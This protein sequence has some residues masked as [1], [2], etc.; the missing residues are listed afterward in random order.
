MERDP[1]KRMRDILNQARKTTGRSP[2]E[3]PVKVSE[4]PKKRKRK[5]SGAAKQVVEEKRARVKAQNAPAPA[6]DVRTKRGK[7]V[8]QLQGAA[9]EARLRGVASGV[10]KH[11][12]SKKVPYTPPQSKALVPG[13]PKTGTA[14]VPAKTRA[15][16]VV[17]GIGSAA[18][19]VPMPWPAK[20]A[21]FAASMGA[22]WLLE[23]A[24]PEGGGGK[25]MTR[26]NQRGQP[27]VVQRGIP[28]MPDDPTW[29]DKAAVAPKQLR[30]N[31][32]KKRSIPTGLTGPTGPD[33]PH[34]RA[35]Q[36]TSGAKPYE[37]SGP[38]ERD[39][40]ESLNAYRDWAGSKLEKP[41]AFSQALSN[42]FGAPVTPGHQTT[43]SEGRLTMEVA[44]HAKHTS[45]HP[46]AALQKQKERKKKGWSNTAFPQK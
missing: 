15:L 12:Q 4:P 24:I 32:G 11:A 37:P 25:K 18:Q 43:D 2:L 10:Q 33:Q 16:S 42:L 1:R 8:K 22:G 28:G 30:P 41:D 29:S 45:K 19:K 44:P 40:R 39:N 34:M 20:L 26:K 23:K 3:E 36:M 5:L 7:I 13:K 9:K 27:V 17:K 6:S 46:V 35:N 31:G 21:T 38:M 14:L